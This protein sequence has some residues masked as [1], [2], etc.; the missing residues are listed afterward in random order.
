MNRFP[1]AALDRSKNCSIC[2]RLLSFHQQWAG[3]TCDSWRCRWTKL[4]REAEAHRQKAALVLG[5]KQPDSYRALVVP[6]R[7]GSIENLSAKRRA[8]HLGFL[9]EL[10]MKVT[11]DGIC[12]AKTCA[13]PGDSDIGPSTALAEA[14]CAVCAGACCHRAGNHAFLDT[15]AL[16]RFMA[17]NCKMEP[18]NIAS[19]YRAYLPALSFAGSCVYHTVNGCAL[20]RLLRADIC[21]NY[22]CSGLKKAEYWARNNG[23][24]HVYVVVR[25]DN[26]IKR[27]AFVQP[28][29]IRHY[30]N[31][32]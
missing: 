27:G 29:A 14:V 15:A 12:G 26:T 5:E 1:V 3:D 21:N 23:T 13:E 19:T 9:D 24:T 6:Y 10:V 18:S 8:D 22:R 4:D 31:R 16:E 2:G 11:Q 30:P 17:L 20:P 7:A 32:R 28:E 25:K